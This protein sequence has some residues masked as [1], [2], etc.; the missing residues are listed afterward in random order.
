[1]TYLD[2][3][4]DDPACEYDEELARD[5]ELAALIMTVQ[6]H[7]TAIECL[8]ASAKAIADGDVAARCAAVEGAMDAVS[9]LYMMLDREN[10]GQLA[11]SLA[12]IYAFTM[13]RMAFI[14]I[15]NNSALAGSL[16]T[17]LKPLGQAWYTIASQAGEH[18]DAPLVEAAHT[19]SR[20]QLAVAGSK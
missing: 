16:V 7:L 20:M 4:G 14:N 2:L 17:I 19:A 9:T 11:D 13:S 1:M 18:S 3:H 15:E 5:R 8:D 12:Q 10:G 6:H